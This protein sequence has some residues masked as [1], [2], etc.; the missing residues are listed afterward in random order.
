MVDASVIESGLVPVA[1]SH[2]RRVLVLGIYV[3]DQPNTVEHVVSVLDASQRFDVDQR[4]VAL[5]GV[6]P[7][8]KVAQKTVSHIAAT[9]P[10]YQILNG[11]LETIPDLAE[12]DYVLTVD[13]DIVLP[14]QFLDPFLTLQ[15]DLN[16]AMAQPARTDNSWID[17]PI[18][19]QQPGV[20][21]RQT[22]F[23]EIGPV[24]SFHRSV[25]DLVF[26][27]DLTSTMGWGLECIWARLLAERGLK[28][29]IIDALPVDHSMRPPVTGY[30]WEV[31]NA[32][33]DQL[34]AKFD[35]LTYDECFH[36]LEVIN[37]A[38]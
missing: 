30:S 33:R 7:S 36:V 11:L 31:A 34:L 32:E 6:A 13:D 35:H 25:Y 28:M 27:F 10:K 23:V 22:L 15:Y 16:F 9:T 17:H 26:P 18:V 12:Y 20:A 8:A 2:R 3:A 4:W 38:G 1:T 5:R 21:A 24:V 29:G 37:F 19:Q 14:G